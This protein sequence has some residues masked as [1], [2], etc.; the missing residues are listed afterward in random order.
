MGY[1]GLLPDYALAQG[2]KEAKDFDSIEMGE[3]SAPHHEKALIPPGNSMDVV[4]S[5]HFLALDC[6]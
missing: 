4:P 3:C 2:G 6:L 1:D 5:L